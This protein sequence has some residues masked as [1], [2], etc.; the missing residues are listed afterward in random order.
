MTFP[1]VVEGMIRGMRFHGTLH[2]HNAQAGDPL[3]ISEICGSDI[4][5]EFE[6]SHGN[7]QVR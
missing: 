4:V 3:E 5:T 6:R 7:Q 2:P 1:N